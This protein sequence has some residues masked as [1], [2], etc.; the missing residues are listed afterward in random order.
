MNHR[1][2]LLRLRK[3]LEYSTHKWIELHPVTF[4]EEMGKMKG[5]ILSALK[6][7]PRK[8]TIGHHSL[9]NYSIGMRLYN[10]QVIFL[11]VRRKS[12]Y[13]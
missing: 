13:E 10:L 5:Q 1:F 11:I 8:S 2:R 4:T 12:D 7:Y 3:N 9:Q 6:K